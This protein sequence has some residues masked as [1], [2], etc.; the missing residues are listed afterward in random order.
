MQ[1]ESHFTDPVKNFF[2][3]ASC[4]LNSTNFEVTYGHGA[5]YFI[6]IGGKKALT[7]VSKFIKDDKRW[8]YHSSFY[9]QCTYFCHLVSHC[10]LCVGLFVVKALTEILILIAR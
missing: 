9:I 2:F 4:V 5:L 6:M 1:M 10:Q 8:S 7:E 3:Y